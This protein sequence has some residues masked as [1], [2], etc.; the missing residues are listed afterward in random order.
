[1]QRSP[2]TAGELTPQLTPPLMTD[3]LVNALGKLAGT[4]ADGIALQGQVKQ[5]CTDQ[6]NKSVVV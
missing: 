6:Q 5:C 4:T 1:M 2:L 3:H